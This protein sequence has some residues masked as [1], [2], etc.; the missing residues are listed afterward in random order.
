[1]LDLG[2]QEFFLIATIAVVVV[3][4]KDLPKVIRTVVGWIRKV[5]TMA[6]DFQGSIEEVAREAELD[7]IRQEALKL[8]DQD[9]SKSILDTVDPDRDLANALRQTQSAAENDGSGENSMLNP[10]TSTDTELDATLKEE[11]RIKGWDASSVT[12]SLSSISPPVRPK[13]NDG[14]QKSARKP[15]AKKSNKAEDN[16]A[17]IKPA[18]K[19]RGKPAMPDGTAVTKSTTARKPR[20]PREAPESKPDADGQSPTDTP[21]TVE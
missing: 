7:E 17:Q 11:D 8:Q 5:R 15:R 20:T 1:M 4:P 2:W 12:T 10:E 9:F 14:P 16:G 21:V 19:S 6:R 18:R 3:G 13:T